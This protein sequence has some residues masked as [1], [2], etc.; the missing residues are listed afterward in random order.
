M[1][2]YYGAAELSLVAWGSHDGDLRP[3]DGVEVRERDGM[4]WVR[5]PYLADV[6][7]DAEG[8]ACV[9]DHGTVTP[10]GRVVVSGRGGTAVL[11]GGVTVLAEEVESALR[12]V[13]TCEV[14]VI[15]LPHP[16]LGEVVAAVVTDAA[17]VGAGHVRARAELARTHR[18]RVWLVA[19][20]LPR[21]TAGKTDRAT[22]RAVAATGALRRVS[23]VGAG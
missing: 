19:D 18:P 22:L 2:H 16:D 20:A 6:P 23:P 1:A 14:A 21:T 7:T 4:L 9:G 5:S 12:P 11:T 3:F 13:L 10:D 17:Q 8:F 15:G